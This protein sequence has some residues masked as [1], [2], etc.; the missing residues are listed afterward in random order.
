MDKEWMSANHLSKEY[1]DGVAEFVKFAVNNA[2]NHERIVCPC[3]SCGNVKSISPET[4]ELHLFK[5]RINQSY[6]CWVKHGETPEDV[7]NSSRGY[8]ESCSSPSSFDTNANEAV[9]LEELV[10]VIE[11]ELENFLEKFERLKTDAETPLYEGCIEFTL[12]STVLELYNLKATSRWSDTSFSSLLSLI[13]LMLLKNNKLSDRLYDVKKNEY[14]ELTHCPKCET[15]R[16]KQNG[17]SAKKAIWYFPIIPRFRRLYSIR[18]EAKNL[19]WHANERIKDD[20]IQHPADSPEWIRFDRK[21]PE[22]GKEDRNL[23]LALSTDGMNPHGMQSSTYSTWPV[24]MVIYNLP[25]WLCMKRK[26]MMLSLLISGPK[27]PGN[28]IDVYL[29][30]LIADLKLLW[31][32]GVEVYD[33]Y[34]EEIFNLRAMLFGTINDFPAYGNLSGYSIKGQLGCP[35]CEEETR[36]MRLQ[37]GRTKDGINARL[38]MVEMGI[39]EELAPQEKGTRTFLQ[40]ATHTLS[41]KEKKSLCEFLATIKVPYGYSSNVRNFVS[42][43]D[44]KLKENSRNVD[45]EATERTTGRKIVTISSDQWEKVH[46]FVLYNSLEIDEY[47][48]IHK[49]EL[50]RQ[51]HH[52]L[53]SWIIKLHNK[54][55][56]R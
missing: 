46:L 22:F 44:L 49:A 48:K 5:Y 55:F 36:S 47:A 50:K 35:I 52:R 17:K 45:D 9:C 2:K 11:E 31:E 39:R 4:C 30:P 33:A 24:M 20:K 27:Q 56:I 34:K 10:D 6:K 53:E 3:L 42:M 51:H 23:R 32:I 7:N 16:Y 21:Y 41:R 1:W 37:H 13:K 38:D 28:D 19:I 26:Y 40:A 43:K 18:Q 29:E 12:L 54:Q 15:S 14:E 8:I 25:P